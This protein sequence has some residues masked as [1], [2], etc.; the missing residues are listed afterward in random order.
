MLAVL[1]LQAM[2]TSLISKNVAMDVAEKL[3]ES[4]AASLEGKKVGALSSV[5]AEVKKV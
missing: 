5:K 2:R 1:H 4:V 3:C